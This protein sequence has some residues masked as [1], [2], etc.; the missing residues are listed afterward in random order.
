[1]IHIIGG[2]GFIGTKLFSTFNSNE[3]INIIDKVP[4]KEYGDHSA[5]ADVRNIEEL[6]KVISSNSIII[7]LAA[8]HRDDV[9]PK[10]LYFDVNVRGAINICDVA[11]IKNVKKIIF[12]SSV[13][14]YGFAEIGT[15]EQGV[16]APYNEY[17]RTKYSAELV[18][19]KWLD[20]DPE[21]RTLVIIRPTV[22]FG[23]KNRGNVYNLIRQIATGLFVMIGDGN[24]RKSLAYV[25][26]VADFIKFSL[27][28]PAGKHL[29]NYI[30]KPD[31]TMNEFVNIVKVI[32]G[33]SSKY[34]IRI[35]YF[36][37]I[38]VGFFID[39]VSKILN[40]SFA[41]SS[42]RIK[43]FCT[44]SVYNTSI[45]KTK[46]VQRI[47]IIDAL[48]STVRYEFLEKHE[49]TNLYYSE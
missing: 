9:S 12:T 4:S 20:E 38:L 34:N 14:V 33:K 17:G 25:D 37:G 36:L 11:R 5:Y 29:F 1:M 3:S 39:A 49:N 40:K 27:S 7:N 26:N 19:Q 48:E 21:S 47:S 24:N 23:Q 15:D 10:S 6:L 8:E 28:L 45:E 43:K 18:Y 35:P 46:F 31:F 22:V 16:I 30:D 13:A 2:S 44:N 41:I 32:V 42:I